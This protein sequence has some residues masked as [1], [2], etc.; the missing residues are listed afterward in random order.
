[1]NKQRKI[2]IFIADDD[3]D[4]RSI[5]RES[6]AKTGDAIKISEYADGSLLMAAIRQM[7]STPPPDLIFLDINMPKKNGLECL[8][9]IRNH[10]HFC[11]VPVIMFTTSASLEDINESYSCGAN[12]FIRKP[13]SFTESRNT[14]KKIIEDFRNDDFKL[15]QRPRDKYLIE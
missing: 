10:E 8:R 14:L 9:E 4:D 1:M 15:D 7:P 12:L 3:S 6:I 2:D 11:K 13:Y 5:F